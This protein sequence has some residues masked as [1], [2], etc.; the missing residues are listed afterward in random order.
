[1]TGAGEELNSVKGL[2]FTGLLILLGLP[3]FLVPG[4]AVFGGII[5]LCAFIIVVLALI[6][7]SHSIHTRRRV[8]K[9]IDEELQV[10]STRPR[11]RP[12]RGP[13][14]TRKTQ[15]LQVIEPSDLICQ[16]CGFVNPKGHRYC[17]SCG[18]PLSPEGTRVY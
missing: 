17:G 13:R 9:K 5:I 4:G 2:W 1:M 15:Q 16:H 10:V 11:T 3:M 18:Y 8:T 12:T 7:W 14:A 6:D